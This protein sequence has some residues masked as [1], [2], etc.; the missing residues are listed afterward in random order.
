[1]ACSSFFYHQNAWWFWCWKS[2]STHTTLEILYSQRPLLI[3]SQSHSYSLVFSTQPLNTGFPCASSPCRL[4]SLYSIPEW[5]HLLP[6][7]DDF[8]S[9]SIK[10]SLLC[11]RLKFQAA[12][13]IFSMSVLPQAYFLF[14]NKLVNGKL[15]FSLTLK[16]LL[17][18]EMCI[19][20]TPV[21]S[22]QFGCLT[23]QFCSDIIYLKLVLDSTSQGFSSTRL[24]LLQMPI[25]S[26]RLSPVFLIYQLKI[27]VPRLQVR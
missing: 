3:I 18:P 7:T 14:S 15:F 16:I 1:M 5:S 24:P 22:S 8:K 27:Q 2:D 9:V 12:Y 21:T 13:L 6:N 4:H 23:I 26:S 25:T 10:A 11:S 20:L 19:F 17:T